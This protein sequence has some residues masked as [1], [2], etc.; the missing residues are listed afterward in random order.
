MKIGIDYSLSSP[1]VCINTSEGEFI[2]EDCTFYY[3]TGTKKYDNTFKDGSVKYVGAGH[4]LYTSEPERYSNIAD[5]VIDIIKTQY[6]PHH[7]SKKHPTIQ[8]ENYSYGSTG[9]V[10]HIAENLGLLKY[11]LKMEC[12]WDYTL[13][14]PS[15]IKKFATDKGNANKDLMLEA[16]EKD[17][18]ANL[19]KIFD[20][21][22]KSPISDVADAYFICKYT[23]E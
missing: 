14:P 2:Y 17:T 15:V 6:P 21:T 20:T 13:L 19:P 4:K 16:F 10:F 11:K 23:E 8:I 7:V 5:W 1:G 18:G 22:S 9:R 12:G 3:L